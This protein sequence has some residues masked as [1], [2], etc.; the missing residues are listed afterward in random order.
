MGDGPLSGVRVIDLTIWVQG[1]IGATLLADLGADVIKV[2]KAGG[3]DFSRALTSLFGVDLRRPDSPNLLWALCNR[4]KRAIT[5][6]LHH[7]A[8][9]PVFRRL[10]EGADVLL[11]NLHPASLAAFEADEASVREVNRRI[12]YARAAG[13]GETGPWADDPCQDTVGM[14]YGGFMFTCANSAD[15]PYYPPG[16]MSDV[17]SGTMLAFGVLA[18]LRERDRSGEGQYVSTSQ[19]QSLMWLQSLNVGVAANLRESFAVQD[20][21][22]PANALVNTYRCGDGRWIALGVILAGPWAD[23]CDAVGL[24]SLRDDERFASLRGRTR[25]AA[26][27][28]QLLDAHFATAPAEHWLRLMRERGLWVSPVHHVEDLLDDEQV[29]ANGYVMEL[30]DGWR[31]PLMPFSLKGHSPAR[32]PAPEYSSGTDEVLGEAGLSEEEIITLK[33]QGAVW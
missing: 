11:T 27:L 29:R 25:N 15:T 32:R 5:L 1:P 28:V 19:L 23:F 6:D 7:E 2:E 13:L 31:A 22:A 24:N 4:N 14:A 16:A 12:V 3:G 17:L 10:L 33:A 9:R 21:Q 26:E 8:A 30:E 20:R 18:A